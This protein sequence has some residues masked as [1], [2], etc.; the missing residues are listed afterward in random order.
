MRIGPQRTLSLVFALVA[1]CARADHLDDFVTEQMIQKQIPGAAV[2]VIRDGK[3]DKARGYGKAN[4]ELKSPVTEETVFEIGSVTKQF[5]AALVMM[6]VEEGKLSLSD[7]LSHYL[8][9]A[10]TGWSNITIRHL[11]THTSGIKNYTGLPGFEASKH[12]SAEQFVQA[13]GVHPLA[14]EPG[15][16]FSYCNSGY[17]L[18]GFVIEKVSG[19]S[20]WQLLHERIFLPAGM[21]AS[22]SRDQKTII[23]NRASG[24]EKEKGGL[25]NRDPDL[26]DVF[27]AGAI[28][29]TILDLIKWNSMLESGK[30]VKSSSLETMWSP[31]KLNSGSLYSYGF[32]W[33]LDDYKGV[34]CIGH[35]GSTS[36]FSSSIQKFPDQRLTIIVLTNS[37]EQGVASSLAR[38]LADLYLPK[39]KS[40]TG[41]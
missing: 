33:R 20:Y 29:S 1:L 37:G 39:S 8:T 41:G 17:N 18:L 30:L 16:K 11:L 3:I 4:L 27:S 5:T 22:Q 36:G 21:R 7:K 28:T 2:A 31:Y 6:L 24:Y 35:S 10:P 25:V 23:L 40:S 38:G 32:G 12:L 13:I 19:K 14:S 26:T 15:E 34:R 9:N